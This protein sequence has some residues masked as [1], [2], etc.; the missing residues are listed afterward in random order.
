MTRPPMP[1]TPRPPTGPASDLRVVTP[2]EPPELSPSAAR[3]LLRIIE[4]ARRELAEREHPA[5]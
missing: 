3:V 2:T 4:R 1:T 5:A